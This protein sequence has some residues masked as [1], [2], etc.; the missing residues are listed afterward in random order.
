MDEAKQN[1][2]AAGVAAV[3]GSRHDAATVVVVAA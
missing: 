1:E 3:G 2:A